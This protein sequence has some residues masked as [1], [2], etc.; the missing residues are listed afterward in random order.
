MTSQQVLIVGG[1]GIVGAQAARLIATRNPTVEIWIG[2]RSIRHANTEAAQIPHA[3]GVAIDLDTLDPLSVLTEMPSVILAAANDDQDH[4]LLSA[5]RRG[6]P[7]I[8][9]TRWTERMHRAIDRLKGEEMTA[10]VILS[11][12]W[13]AG[14]PASVA[15]SA[16]AE[17]GG[18]QRIEIDILYAM[19]DKAGPNSI[20]YVDRLNI[21][22]T[23]MIDGAWRNAKT[24]SDPKSV[25][26]SNGRV[27]KC[28]RFDT[29]DQFTYVD[30]LGATTVASRM[31][32]DD[33]NVLRFIRFVVGSG[34]WSLLPRKT[35]RA[36]IYNPG[37][38][39]PHEVIVT[40][41]GQNGQKRIS[42]IDP[43]GQTHMT[44]VG[45]TVQVERVLGLRERAT[46][47]D[48]ISFPEAATDHEL[49]IKA[50]GEMGISIVA[51][52]KK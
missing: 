5:A 36:L 14:V 24:F 7:I 49:G 46:P 15:A 25:R 16:V 40:V 43:L 26:F 10:P 22:F 11:S 37:A 23:V 18:E 35:R 44:A 6:I 29:P 19:K 2:G 3:S 4:L 41:T 8:D 39:A 50:L 34:I 30:T 20:D 32:Y 51:D 48:G 52:S 21:P 38:G 42:V 13:M 45:A 31:S 17:L 9:I 33:A 47:P 27:F 1:Y 12:S 28:F